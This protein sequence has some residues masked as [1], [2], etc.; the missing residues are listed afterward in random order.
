LDI[1]SLEAFG[2]ILRKRREDKGLSL[3][4]LAKLTGISKPYLANIE[5]A[6]TPGPPT[7]GK[8]R[9]LEVALGFK[10]G[11]LQAAADWLRTPASV[12]ALVGKR[13][14]RRADGAIDLDAV[15][16]REKTKTTPPPP[17]PLAGDAVS[18]PIRLAPVINKVAAGAAAE[19]GDLDY[20]A[21]VADAYVPV[22]MQMGEST[23][24]AEEK[25]A[26][27]SAFAARVAGDSMTPEFLPGDVVIVAPMEA[28]DGED[29][30]V[31]LGPDENF[32]TT[33]KRVYF[34]PDHSGQALAVRLVP[35]NAAH[36]ERVVPLSDVTGIYPVV[37][38]MSAVR[39]RPNP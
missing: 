34:I 2:A 30:L 31:R 39:G 11:Q 20:P 6:R 19:H 28:R 7:E 10:E 8:L 15:V 36:A 4:G 18:G 13:T 22:P 24:P 38:R 29:C 1:D 3:E 5:T 37:Y 23:A 35:R 17:P 16:A 33:L 12:R 27:K 26:W 14:P 21:G 32:A 25:A 9:V